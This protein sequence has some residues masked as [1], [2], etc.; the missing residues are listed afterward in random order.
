MS[1]KLPWCEDIKTN[2]CRLI[3]YNG[4]FK[5][6][7]T[8]VILMK[9]LIITLIKSGADMDNIFVFMRMDE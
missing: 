1:F 5:Y 3:T 7:H 6:L 2:N 8:D 4:W 9:P